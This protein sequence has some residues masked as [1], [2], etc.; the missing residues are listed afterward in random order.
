[1]MISIPYGEGKILLHNLP[2]AFTNFHLL[3]EDGK[4][5]AEFIL[6]QLNPGI[7]IWD[8]FSRIFNFSPDDPG[9]KYSGE[10]PLAYILSIPALAWAFYI[11]LGSCVIYVVFNAKR[12]QAPV[13]V[14]A[15]KTNTSLEFVRM[16]GQLYYKDKDHRA[17]T[18]RMMQQFYTDA[19]A[20]YHIQDRNPDSFAKK[21]SVRSGVDIRLITDIIKKYNKLHT[22]HY[23]PDDHHVGMFY[24]AIQEFHQKKQ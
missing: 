3:K 22:Q 15:P 16:V 1:M 23:E 17:L 24:E 20:R 21:L 12:K 5:H 2:I 9:I 10:T 14:V 4:K 13:Q 19:Y 7:V 11:L 6:S 18:E 8:N